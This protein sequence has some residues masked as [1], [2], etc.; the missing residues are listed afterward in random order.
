MTAR[1][2][3]VRARLWRERVL[4]IFPHFVSPGAASSDHRLHLLVPFHLL[5][6]HRGSRRRHR[7]IAVRHVCPPW[8]VHPSIQGVSAHARKEWR[9][10]SFAAS[11]LDSRARADVQR[12]PSRGRLEPR[13][14]PNGLPDRTHHQHRRERA[15][16]PRPLSPLLQH[17]RLATSDSPCPGSTF[18][19]VASSTSSPPPNQAVSFQMTGLTTELTLVA[20]V[21]SWRFDDKSARRCRGFRPPSWSKRRAWG[22]R[23]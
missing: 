11:P 15:H 7:T 16:N 1:A 9:R 13:L 4:E 14:R 21:L 12:S 18:F 23:S 8:Q 6:V 17:I 5:G 22:P 10:P 20:S 2:L 19:E 3:A